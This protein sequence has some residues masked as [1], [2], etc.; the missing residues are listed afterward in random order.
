MIFN[1]EKK[2]GIWMAQKSGNTID[3]TCIKRQTLFRHQQGSVSLMM[4]ASLCFNAQASLKF[5]IHIVYIFVS[6]FCHYI[7]CKVDNLKL[8]IKVNHK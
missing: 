7:V 5:L 2:N 3:T 6:F 4:L 1:D 8:W